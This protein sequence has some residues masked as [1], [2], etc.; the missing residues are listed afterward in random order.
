MMCVPRVLSSALWPRPLAGNRP[1]EPLAHLIPG[2]RHPAR[3]KF[4]GV[5]LARLK[6]RLTC[7]LYTSEA[8]RMPAPLMGRPP[9]HEAF[10]QPGRSAVSGC[11]LTATHE[12]GRLA[13]NPCGRESRGRDVN[14]SWRWRYTLSIRGWLRP[15]RSRPH[16]RQRPCLVSRRLSFVSYRLP[17]QW[18]C[19]VVLPARS[20]S[21]MRLMSCSVERTSSIYLA[22][23]ASMVT[24]PAS[25]IHGNNLIR[26]SS[27]P[28]S[29]DRSDDEPILSQDRN[30]QTFARQ[31]M[32]SVG[33]AVVRSSTPSPYNQPCKTR[34]GGWPC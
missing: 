14:N 29:F 11:P 34:R 23:R 9:G 24:A 3:L 32:H 26:K 16:F 12:T 18:P 33:P 5:H 20:V 27:M 13:A 10:P 2:G 17:V 8:G 1:N 30:V 7:I 6:C 21:R 22:I 25:N 4:G 15:R 31:I 28:A 19:A